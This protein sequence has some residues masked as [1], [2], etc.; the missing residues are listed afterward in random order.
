MSSNLAIIESDS[1]IVSMTRARAAL[2]EAVTVGQTKMLIDVAYA[3]EIY[4]K[5]HLLSE[6]AIRGATSVK[7]E[8]TRKLGEIL[9]A[10]PKAQGTK[11][12]GRDSFGGTN[13][14]PPKNDA[15]T[16]D[17]LGLTKRESALAQ[18]LA[19]LPE[20]EFEQVRTGA[21]T[22][23]KAVAAVD[24]G[25]K[26][27]APKPAAQVHAA[28]DASDELAEA[29]HTITELAEENEL[30]RAQIAVGQMDAP[31]VER[32]SASELIA[33]LRAQVK[34]FEAELKAMRISRDRFQSE[35]RELMTQVTR[36]AA[37]LKK[38]RATA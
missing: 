38:S 11:L 2:A 16:L 27:E 37:E 1:V 24:E 12:N 36:N 3:A 6:D 21:V 34:T 23:A 14:S 15:P 18:K 13:V 9:L 22:M 31:E 30:L 26:K 25:K 33:E 19:G 8:A 7:V 29:A 32:I 5:R 10:T 4:A 35:N 28:N 20:A 17:E